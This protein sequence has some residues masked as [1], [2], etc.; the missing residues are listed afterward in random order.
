[1]GIHNLDQLHLTVDSYVKNVPIVDMHTHLYPENFTGLLLWG[2]DELLNYHYLI[3]ETLRYTNLSYEAFWSMSKMEQAEL[4]WKTLFLEHSPISEACR[5]VLT[6]LKRLGLDVTKRNL[7]EYR[8]FFTQFST[9]QYMDLVFQTAGVESAVMT[10]D[11]FDDL[12]RNYWEQGLSVDPHLKAALR[13]DVLLNSWD[14][15]YLKL[16]DMGY[17]VESVLSKSTIQEVNRFLQDWI[18]KIHPLYLAVSLSYDFNYPEDTIR[19]QLIE[20]CILPVCRVHQMPFA[21]MIGVKRQADPELKSAGDSVGKADIRVVETLCNKYPNNKFMVTMLSRENQHELCVTARKF[22]NLL[23]FGCWWFLNNPSLIEEITRMRMEL[24]GLS[25]V[26]QHSDARVLDQ[27]IYKW[28][29]SRKV[30]GKVLFEK[31]KDLLDAGWEVTD[32]E[33]KRDV[34][35]LFGGNFKEFLAFQL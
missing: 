6:V 19:N 5:G 33:I 21:L 4:A 7:H 29:H 11:P 9:H 25:M 35:M 27:L 30:I 13:I 22:R 34:E 18:A 14:Q 23:I 26:P 1:M 8:S 32:A 24:L 28:E 20:K 31:Y 2:V 16:K 10:N 3:A 15:A 12:E 17:K